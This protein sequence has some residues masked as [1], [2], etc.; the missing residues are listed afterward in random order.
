MG[1]TEIIVAI[2]AGA[3]SAFG[4]IIANNK[5]TAVLQAVMETKLDSVIEQQKR[6][7]ERLD[8][9]NHLNERVT[10]LEVLLEERGKPA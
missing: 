1:W 6:Q 7:E 8:A 3:V 9:H 10:R 5:R 2:I 4:A